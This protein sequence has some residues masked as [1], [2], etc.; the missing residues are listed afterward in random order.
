MRKGDIEEGKVDNS[1]AVER[2]F[3]ADGYDAEGF[4][5]EGLSRDGY[6]RQDYIDAGYSF[7]QEVSFPPHSFRHTSR[8]N[9]I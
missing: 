2:V 3:D 9:L 5:A 8:T 6:S 1:A 4:N 7:S